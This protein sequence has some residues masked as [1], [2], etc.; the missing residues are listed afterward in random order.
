MGVLRN[1]GL[2]LGV[3]ALLHMG[4]EA[5][6]PSFG[7]DIRPILSDKC[8]ACH[9]PDENARKGKLRLDIESEA[10]RALGTSHADSLAFARIT[11]A[12]AD[13]QMPPP[14][15]GKTLSDA[16]REK[17]KAWI[18]A[19]AKYEMHWAFVAPQLPPTPPVKQAAWP[20]N[21]IDTFVLAKLEAQGLAPAAEA[22]PITLL[23]RAHL[24]LTGLP[25][26]P[27]E[28]E[29]FV[30]DAA[31]GAYER[32]V[33][34]LLASPHFGERWG[35][36]W[37][38]TARYADS[39]GYSVDAPRS[40]WLYR[41][42]VINAINADLP[43]D[44]FVITQLAGDLLPDAGVGE[45]T[46]TGF[47]RNTMINEEGGIDK[48]EFR[49]EAVMD[50]TNTVGTAFLGL[51][52]A[53]ARCHTH[54]YDPIE[55]REYFRMLAFL[56]NDDEPTLMVPDAAYAAKRVQADAALEAL[57]AKRDAYLSGATDQRKAWE[58]GLTLA[59]VQGLEEA[60]RT[61]LTTPWDQRNEDQADKALEVFRRQDLTAIA[62]DAAI[63]A[64][65]KALPK[66]PTTMVVAA[67]KEMRETHLRIAGDY[68]RPGEV[69]TPGGIAA[70]NPM[71]GDA[72]TRLDLARWL[73]ARE[74]PLLARVTVN[75][76][77]M[78]LFGR[79]LVETEDDFGLQGTAP[80][81]PEL[82]DWL[83][84]T[85]MDRGWSVKAML[86]EIVCSATYRQASI[87]RED[88]DEIDPR[89]TL[90]ARQNR[91][92]LDAEIIRDAGL[93]AAGVL[94]DAIGGPSVFPLQPD[95]VMT[96]GQQ[97]RPWKVSE[98]AD[99]YRRGMYTYFWRATP[100][101]ALTVFDAPDAQ[102]ACTR[103]NRSNTP[104]QALTL[105]NDAAYVELAEALSKRLAQE[106]GDTPDARLVHAFR[107]CLAR[108][109]ADDER[110]ILGDLYAQE[111]AA[112]GEDAAWKTVAR[113]MLNLDEFITRE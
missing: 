13:D 11:T 26:T 108:A 21:T 74:N 107:V 78:Q 85:F 36:H 71:P 57:K 109:P 103:R 10:R 23:R 95:G 59:F 33:D 69:V 94:N 34:A 42:W 27:A 87:R 8:F 38:D 49:L 89:N 31:P 68:T 1:I 64:A 84:V 111:R 29:A 48:E 2:G 7:R 106:G 50:R 47:L 37:L 90:L 19:G 44:Q 41:D 17:L 52:L 65:L 14:E 112:V 77:W 45:K 3:A 86:R 88:L 4:A 105:L 5:E 40:I 80:S 92:R 56:N 15:S 43:F 24:D 51:T 83:A 6:G 102:A 54:K 61:A 98:G 79:G 9:G 16:E 104:L 99:R 97:D 25:P 70:L 18:D 28:V 67:R 22:D 96:L 63:D 60:E 58:A 53:C 75:R 76:F 12:D 81:H 62:Q 110:K 101:P 35:R 32:A 55:Q 100:H 73:T 20:R 113:A 93:T 46:A 66:A 72:A 82:L 30:A 91:V 39:N